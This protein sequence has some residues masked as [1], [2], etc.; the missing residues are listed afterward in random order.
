MLILL[1]ISSE[2]INFL[3]RL[4]R[5]LALPFREQWRSVCDY[6]FWCCTAAVSRS[7]SRHPKDV[8]Y[9]LLC[10]VLGT[11]ISANVYW[12]DSFDI[13][14]LSQ[15]AGAASSWNT[16]ESNVLLQVCSMRQQRKNGC[17]NQ[18][19]LRHSKQRLMASLSQFRRVI[20]IYDCVCLHLSISSQ[21]GAK[22]GKPFIAAS[23]TATGR[24]LQVQGTFQDTGT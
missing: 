5:L 11:S 2:I 17:I 3:W 23:A 6:C 4:L 7:L 8:Y 9:S 18:I 19:A 12:G 14:S 16:D 10:V 22:S 13:V 21:G 24:V 20:E 15:P 1:P